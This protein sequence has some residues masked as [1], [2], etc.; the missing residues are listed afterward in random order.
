MTD[1]VISRDL[2]DPNHLHRISFLR[3]FMLHRFRSM[4]VALAQALCICVILCWSAASAHGQNLAFTPS[5]ASAYA[6]DPTQSHAQSSASYTGPLNNWPTSGLV[7]NRPSQAIFDANG[8]AYLVESSAIWAVAS[9]K[10]GAIPAVPAAGTS[11]QAGYVYPVSG[12]TSPAQ[13]GTNWYISACTTATDNWGD[14]CPSTDVYMSNPYIAVDPKGNLYLADSNANEIRVIYAAG[15]IPGLPKGAVPGNIYAVAGTGTAGNNGDGPAL[16]AELNSP[17]GVALDSNGNIYISDA[18]NEAVRVIYVAGNVPNLPTSP[19]V[20]NLYTIA[21]TLGK[22]CFYSSSNTCGDGGVATSAEFAAYMGAIALDPSGNIYV[23]DRN[24]AVVR[25]ISASGGPLPGVSSPQAGYIY[26]AAGVGQFGGSTTPG[27]QATGFQFSSPVDIATDQGGDFYVS[28]QSSS[29]VY[30]IDS[31]GIITVAF[32]GASTVCAT[33]TDAYGDGCPATATMLSFQSG[34]AFDPSGNLYIADTGDNLIREANVA[35]SALTLAGTFGLPIPS[36]TVTVSNTGSQPL[37]LSGISVAA[38]FSQVA[39]GGSTDC[40]SSTQLQPGTSCQIGVG[41][42]P[43]QAGTVTGSLQVSSNSLN[44]TS[45]QNTAGLTANI[46]QAGSSTVL[47]ASPAAPAQA[48]L[49]QPI[50]LTAKVY[51]QTGVTQA[52]P[53]GTVTFSNGSTVLG[54]GTLNSSDV[55]TY[56]TSSLTAGSYVVTAAYSGDTNFLTSDSNAAFATVASTAVPT[57]TLVASPTSTTVG[58]PVTLTATVTAPSGGGSPT[59]TIVFQNGIAP[60]S[61]A[62]ALSGGS[63]TFSTTSLPVGTNTLYAVYSGNLAANGSNGVVVTVGANAQLQFT[64]GVIAAYAGN[65]NQG[66]TASGPATSAE[67]N[68]PQTV[69]YDTAGNLYFADAG[70]TI[71]RV[72]ASGNGTIPGVASPVKGNIYTVAG[73]MGQSCTTAPC[74]DGGPANQAYLN[75]GPSYGPK[76]AVAVDVAGNIYIADTGDNEIRKV[77]PNGIISTIAGTFQSGY[78]PSSGDGGPATK[79]VL[80]MIL[81]AL[82]VDNAGNLYLIDGS[83]VRKVDAQTQIITTIAGSLTG[84]GY[85]GDG[86]AATA[87]TLS[88][89]SGLALD[90]QDDLYISDTNNQVVREVSAQ[91]GLISTVAGYNYYPFG[92]GGCDANYADNCFAGDGG[93]ATQATLLTP[94]AVTVDAAGNLYVLDEGND[95]IRMVDA[96]TGIINTIA[97]QAEQFCSSGPC[98]DGGL[99]TNATFGEPDGLALDESGNLAVSDPW[100][101]A[102]REITQTP[103][104]LNFGTPNLGTGVGQSVTVTNTGAQPLNLTGITISAGFTQAASGGTDCSASTTLAPAQ[105]CVIDV[106]FFPTAAQTYNGTVTVASNSTNVTSGNN[107]ITLTGTGVANSGTQSQSISFQT[108]AAP[109]DQG[110]QIALGA[111]ASSGLPVEYLV[112]GPG[113]ILNNGTASASLKITGT[114]AIT[115]TA[116]QFG[117]STYAAASPVTV[118]FTAVQPVL[119]I[120]AQNESITLG[121]TV[122]AYTSASAYTATGFIPGDS[123]SNLSGIPAISVVSASGAVVP[124]GSTPE[125]GSYTLAIAQG[126]LT[127]PSYYKLS[128]VNGT[129][130]VSGSN[131]QTIVFTP[132]P[133]NLTYGAA[134]VQLSAVANDATTGKAD[135]LPITFSTTSTVDTISGNLLTIGGAGAVTITASQAGSTYYAG[136]SATQSVV[137]AKAPLS[138]TAVNQTLAQGVG[139]PTLNSAIDYTFG[140]FQNQET[141]AVLTGAPVLTIVDSN[142]N[143]L[144]PGSTPPVGT[145]TIQITQGS[146]SSSNYAFNFVNGK[147]SVVNGQSQTVTFPA[148][149][150]VTYGASPIAMHATASSSL[151]LVYTIVSGPATVAGNMVSV[152]GAGTIKVQ[153]TQPGNNTYAP[154]SATQSFNVGPALL[155]VIASNVTRV[156]NT[157]NPPLTGYTVTG[158]VN[159]DTQAVVSGSPMITTTALPGSPVGTYPIAISQQPTDSAQNPITAANYTFAFVNGTLTI[160]P[161][162]PTPDFSLSIAPAVLGIPQGQIQQTTITLTPTNYYQGTTKLS[163]GNLPANMSCIFSPSTLAAD[164]TGNTVTGTLTINTNA[165]STPVAQVSSPSNPR[166]SARTLPAALFY[167]PGELIALTV[168]LYRRK[169]GKKSRAAQ[170]IVLLILI[171]G[172]FGLTACAGNSSSAS[173]QYTAPGNYTVS[174]NVADLAGGPSHTINLTVD[175]Q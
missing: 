1:N 9:G 34:I 27:I 152:N 156:N 106:Q 65:Y 68:S 54:T 8:N 142:G 26:T 120:T 14:G 154:A 98:G 174:V 80:S 75:L 138:V 104:A 24:N 141:S 66:Y 76:G 134:S 83:A 166:G 131:P 2:I 60:I 31:A 29:K 112:S 42:S 132:L 128:F 21:G 148:V 127:A 41:V 96:Q 49:G 69:A 77:A 50:T 13:S 124:V 143:V 36:Q 159:G 4:F 88:A 137:V 121:Q 48:G 110:M 153:A 59:G 150:N 126:T 94:S 52:P 119:T 125:A 47:T 90:G 51:P 86:G 91:T 72:V 84:S 130:T 108:P 167:L 146:L 15:S 164:G 113:L 151:G 111:T 45:G 19:T 102:V 175:V 163:C 158:F 79:A 25:V 62:I 99:A 38:P 123:S 136:A 114:G 39:T 118:G 61:S 56:T 82:A 81:P 67:V 100:V 149:Q 20:D 97:G 32:G 145:Y 10:G 57:V 63:A 43:T 71:I 40:D 89:P 173:S 5:M 157:P 140:Q 6:G 23:S 171:T 144:A 105:Q 16:S 155:T 87:A 161:G 33:H 55:A 122:P 3:G 169:R 46:A 170:L 117:N 53:T 135:G 35:D 30:K 172:A 147:F 74:G 58:Q 78:A 28:D 95:V 7:F 101:N 103:T 37:T 93:P 85:S 115:V 139:L 162:G 129:F 116:Y 107:I 92:F 64:P 73:V 18:F 12:V 44:A 70:N 165:G 17:E 168:T 160:T 109:Y 22:T 133:S 11:P